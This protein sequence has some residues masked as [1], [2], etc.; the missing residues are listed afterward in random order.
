MIISRSSQIGEDSKKMVKIKPEI[1]GL[2]YPEITEERVVVDIRV[3]GFDG[4]KEIQISASPIDSLET[5]QEK[6]QKLVKEPH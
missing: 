4:D 5:L 6:I 3:S 2:E 1:V